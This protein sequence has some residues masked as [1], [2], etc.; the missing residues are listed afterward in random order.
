MAFDVPAV[1]IVGRSN[2]G[3]TTLLESLIPLLQARGYRVAAVKHYVHPGIEFDVPGKDSYRL[4]HAGADRVVLATPDRVVHVRRCEREPTLA[5]VV[6]EIRDVDLVLIEGHKQAV[7]PKIEVNR[8]ERDAHLV[9]GDDAQLIGVVSDQR[10]D[11]DV[12]QFD[13]DDVAGVADLLERRVLA[14]GRT[15]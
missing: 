13:L 12:P 5:E 9:C 15:D 2:S 10:F 8:R 6:A 3:K 11:V 7:V 14:A 4:A 1:A